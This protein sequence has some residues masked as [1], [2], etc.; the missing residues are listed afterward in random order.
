VWL[1]VPVSWNVTL[2]HLVIGFRHFKGLSCLHLQGLEFRESTTQL[3][4]AIYVQ[5][6]F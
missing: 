5:T 1:A 2:C 3:R 6:L 4:S